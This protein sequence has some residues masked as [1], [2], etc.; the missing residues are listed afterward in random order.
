MG[1]ENW[2]QVKEI[3]GDALQQTPEER[4]N[5]L[6]RV[7]R[8][9]KKL[10]SEVESLLASFDDATSF[11]EQPAAEKVASLIIESKHLEMGKRFGHYEIIKQIGEG[12]MGEVY[13][14]KDN[15]LDRKV[16]VKIL[17]EKFANHESN[18]NRFILEAKAASALNHPNILVIHEI[19]ET[20]DIHYI[21]SEFIEGETLRERLGKSVMNLGEV[22]DISIQI[23]NALTAAHLAH[24]VH[25]DIKPENIIIRPDGFVKVLDFGLAKLIG[26]KNRS[27]IGLDESTLKQNDTAKGVIMGTINYMS[28]EQAKGE[29]VD[30][31]T[32]IFS[33][34]VLVYEMNTGQTP[35]ASDS[36]SE[37][38]ANLINK[39][40]LPLARFAANVPNELQ[41][42][43]AKMLRK[44][45]DERYQTIKGLLADLR[46][47]KENLS[48]EEK[49]ERSAPP[50]NENATAIL[51]A[52]TGDVNKR[53]AETQHS[54]LQ[55]IARKPFAAFLFAA[56]FVAVVG[57]GYY[58]FVA[59]NNV[60]DSDANPLKSIAVLP[61]VNES[62]DANFDYLSDG[63]SESVID[64]LSQL[65]QLKVIARSSSFKYRGE[66]ID[67]Q[68]AANKLGVQV[69][70][71]GRIIQRGDN[72]S[73]RVEMVDARD[74]R[75]V[76]SEQYN[77][78]TTDAFAVQQEV[79]QTV[80]EQLRLK[81]SGAQ[82]QK[83]A[84]R[85]MVNPQAYDLLLKGRF[86][87]GKGGTD[88]KKK[89]IEY[90]RQAVAIDPN[91]ALANVYLAGSYRALVGHSVLNPKEFNPK[92]KAAVQKALELDPNLPEAHL[93]IGHQ[94]QDDWNW[95]AAETE[96][97]RA[98]EL[99]P[100]LVAARN[101][102]SFYL[103]I[104]GRHDEAIA[105]AGRTKELDPLTLGNRVAFGLA[106]D[107]A[108]RYDE[109]IAEFKKILEV[110]KNYYGAIYWLSYAYLDKG[111]YREAIDSFQ[112]AI[113]LGGDNPSNQIYL[114][115]SY[116]KAGEREKAQAILKQLETSNEYVSPGE[117]PVLYVALGDHEKACASFEKAYAA[118]DLQLQ[119]LKVDPSFDP[120]RDDP[121]F[122]DLIKRVGLP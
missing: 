68:D 7:C 41:H 14:A 17:N 5:F 59:N 66:N 4:P 40:P 100:N 2:R 16:A 70:V 38:F 24:I 49:L 56:F 112:E 53:T 80:S 92:A 91:Y 25:R 116:A 13:L 72:L 119:F 83:L 64:R 50:N 33:F 79:A 10:R 30:E 95:A 118:H 21:I 39:E 67:I 84:K 57:F 36:I 105:E 69:I 15:K 55:P 63:L 26:Q 43:V 45:K 60:T 11:M 62:G 18:L 58:F 8:D 104:M 37:T 111:M 86:I 3:F 6:D 121:R 75:Q 27:L 115:A 102:Y 85:D 46:E 113:R 88:N 87:S 32:D 81:L 108:R 42:I 19:G 1:Q 117:L 93:M 97:K 82:E 103:S 65:P 94:Y 29:Q 73:I 28:P 22:L 106:L 31:R 89:A 101:N 52:T 47:L 96:Y 44:N 109:A 61:F 77:R 12:G 78:K 71:T 74:N 76:W 99:N 35:F 20:D 34:G 23:A 107:R 54:F 120:L 51:Q 114:G 110:D 90:Y 9:D 48:F 122:Q 98:I